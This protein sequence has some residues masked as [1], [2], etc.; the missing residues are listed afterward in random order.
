MKANRHITLILTVLFIGFST[1]NGQASART[2]EKEK[3]NRPT[4]KRTEANKARVKQTQAPQ[5]QARQ[6]QVRKTPARQTQARQTQARQTP[7][8]QTQARQSSAK[9]TQ[10]YR[11]QTREMNTRKTTVKPEKSQAQRYTTV[12]WQFFSTSSSLLQKSVRAV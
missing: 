11:V 1:L 7:A 12:S 9:Q 6:S 8:R 5:T 2:G 10:A 4:V 3:Q